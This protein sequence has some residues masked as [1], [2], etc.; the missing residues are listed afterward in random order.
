MGL[1]GFGKE[2]GMDGLEEFTEL[3]NIF[4]SET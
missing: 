2:Q 3:R 4:I 1:S